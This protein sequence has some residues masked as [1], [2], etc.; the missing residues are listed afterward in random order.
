M[1]YLLNNLDLDLFVKKN[2]YMLFWMWETGEARV[3]GLIENERSRSIIGKQEVVNLFDIKQKVQIV[4]VKKIPLKKWD[5]IIVW[6]TNGRYFV[7]EV[8]EFR[9]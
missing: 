5:K 3:K 9:N 4:P 1:I 8:T 2:R 7:L 6:T